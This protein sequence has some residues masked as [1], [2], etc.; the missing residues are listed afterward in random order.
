MKKYFCDVCGTELDS[1]G[2]APP[3]PVVELC[4]LEDLCPRCENFAQKLDF[5]AL[6]LGELRRLIESKGE[7]PAAPSPTLRGKAAKEKREI[8][9]AVEAYR[10]EAGPGSIPQLAKLTKVGEG[11]LRDMISCAPLPM[12]TWRK[13]GKALGVAGVVGKEDPS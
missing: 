4:R 11:E 7:V 3:G 12:A 9:A 13:V 10:K 8:L 6:I 5:S 1:G 2:N